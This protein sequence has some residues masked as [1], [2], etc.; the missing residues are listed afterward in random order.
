M[1]MGLEALSQT[2]EDNLCTEYIKSLLCGYEI[3]LKA[4]IE[5]LKVTSGA[6]FFDTSQSDVFPE[7]DFH[8]CIEYDKFDFIVKLEKDKNGLILIRN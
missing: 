7:T 1:C 4:G 3:D 2:E 8:M 5:N 6:K